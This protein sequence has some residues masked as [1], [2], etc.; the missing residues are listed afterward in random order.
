M[1]IGIYDVDKTRFPN[2][3]LMKLSA[4]EKK[5]G[6]EVEIFE[7]LLSDTYD[8]VYVSKVFTYHKEPDFFPKYTTYGGT[9]FQLFNVTLNARAEHIMP[10]YKIFNTKVSIGF[11]TRGCPNKCPWCVVPHKEGKIH[12][13]ADFHEFYNPK[14][15]KMVLL[16]NNIIAHPHGLE[17][18]EEIAKLGISIDVNAGIEAR[19]VNKD[20]AKILAKQK[21]FVPIRIGCDQDSAM[22]YVKQAAETLRLAGVTPQRFI[23]YV[24]LKDD[25]DSAYRRCE[26][27]RSINIDPYCQ[28][29]RDP[30]GETIVP[31][32]HMLFS[33]WVNQKAFFRNM[34]WEEFRKKKIGWKTFKEHRSIDTCGYTLLEED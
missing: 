7:P 9:G 10:D 28:P 14:F 12:E 11:V 16:D 33:R 23:G 18:L 1:K 34:P 30:L 21:W 31:D 26:F 13:H 4:F 5:N 6:N 19:R 25:L 29:Y 32:E 22:K 27:L 8:W 2:L 15:K 20:I 17:Q 3:A 24:L